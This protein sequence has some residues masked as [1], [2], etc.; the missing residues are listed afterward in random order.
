MFSFTSSS[1]LIYVIN[2]FPLSDLFPNRENVGADFLK[3]QKLQKVRLGE[4][5]MTSRHSLYNKE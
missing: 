5:Q 3:L 4:K 2:P 1:A